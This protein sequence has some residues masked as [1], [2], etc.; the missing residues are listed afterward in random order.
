MIA[1]DYSANAIEIIRARFPYLEAHVMDINECSL[2]PEHAAI[3]VYDKGTLDAYLLNESNSIAG[4]R[5]AVER[6]VSSADPDK[7]RLIVTS[8]NHSQDEL[9]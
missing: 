9:I 6:L 4:Y 2:A 7:R 5:S 8:C 1:L 3:A